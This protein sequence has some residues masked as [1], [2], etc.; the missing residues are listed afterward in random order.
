M[1][2]NFNNSNNRGLN[3]NQN[4]FSSKGQSKGTDLDNIVDWISENADK[5]LLGGLALYGTSKILSAEKDDSL[6]DL[7]FYIWD[8]KRGDCILVKGP[9]ENVLIDVGGNSE[10]SPSKHIHNNHGTDIDSL[11]ISHP[12]EDHIEDLPNFVDEYSPNSIYWSR[13]V[14]SIPYIKHRKENRYPDKESYQ[15]IAGAFLEHFDKD[16]YDDEDYQDSSSPIKS[17]RNKGAVTYTSYRLSRDKLGLTPAEEL[18]DDKGVNL[19]SLSYLTVVKYNGFKLVTMGDLEENAIETLIGYDEVANDLEGTDVLIAPH[20]GLDS[21]Y[22][23]EL[24]NYFTPDIV[25][26]SDA[27]SADSSAQGKYY[28]QADGKTVARRNDSAET[29]YTVSTYNDGVIYLGVGESGSYKVNID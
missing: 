11:I 9:E 10:F 2:N 3:Y 14:S 19:N 4:Q 24:F 12:D 7:Q 18:D 22:T 15:E 29:R 5:L 1:F 13:P 21:S 27:G 17:E 23:S 16:E 6:H 25:A 28:Q 26:I 20:H 8:V